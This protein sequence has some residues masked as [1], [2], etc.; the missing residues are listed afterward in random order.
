M[1]W[2]GLWMWAGTLSLALL[3]LVNGTGILDHLRFALI[4]AP[5]YFLLIASLPL[6]AWLKQVAPGAAVIGCALAIP[7][8]Y[9][10]QWKG[11]WR[12]LGQDVRRVATP[13]DVIVI[14]A[15]PTAFLTGPGKMYQGMA[16]YAEPIPCPVLVLDKPIDPTALT[17]LKTARQVWFVSGLQAAR[18]ED[19]LPG[20][21]FK[22][23]V[24]GRIFT[25]RLFLAS[26][27]K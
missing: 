23:V 1:A 5:A 3:D 25:G 22:A 12:E 6:R 16:Y 21:H 9:D 15:A 4:A 11:E 24:P 27:G 18:P 7:Y 8:G 19:Y 17:R 14:S 26:E 20:W 2:C 13:A 10:P